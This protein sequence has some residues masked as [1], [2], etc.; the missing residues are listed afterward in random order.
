MIECQI[1]NKKFKSITNTHLTKSHN[2]ITLQYYI[3]KYGEFRSPENIIKRKEAINNIDFDDRA[4]KARVTSDNTR[5]EKYGELSQRQLQICYGGLLGDFSIHAY[6]KNRL[7]GNYLECYHSDDQLEYLNWINQELDSVGCKIHAW[8]RYW[9][10]YKK[11]YKRNWI[12][13]A[14]HPTF[15]SLRKFTYNNDGQDSHKNVT[16]EWLNKL[17]PLGLAVWYM[18]DGQFKRKKHIILHTQGFT[19]DEHITIQNYF[20]DRWGIRVTPQ[21]A[22]K[23]RITGDQLYLTYISLYDNEKFFNIIREHVLPCFQYK[24]N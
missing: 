7:S 19:Y 2:G 12:T 14:S 22:C 13:T 20:E 11:D 16:I 17:E 9:N 18:D 23:S 5:I 8:T 1:C 15:T 21:K 4:K 24:L 6:T 3:E 10:E